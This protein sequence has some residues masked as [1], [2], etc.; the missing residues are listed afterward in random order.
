[1][2]PKVFA[3]LMEVLPHVSR[4]IPMADMFFASK[5]ASEKANE[6]VIADMAEGVRTDLG[7][8]TAAHE[9]LYRQLQDQGLQIGSAATDLQ[10]ARTAVESH[11]ARIASIE[12]RVA[13]LGIWVKSAVALLIVALALLIAILLRTH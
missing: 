9:A 12:G 1:M 10:R 5:T 4:L 13:A 8:V 2:W 6:T 3:Q 11:A 7:K